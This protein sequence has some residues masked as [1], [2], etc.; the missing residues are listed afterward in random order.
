MIS[1]FWWVEFRGNPWLIGGFNMPFQVLLCISIFVCS[2]IPIGSMY[3][4]YANIGGI[5]MVNVTIYSIHGSYGIE[6]GSWSQKKLSHAFH[7]FRW[8]NRQRGS[9]ADTPSPYQGGPRRWNL[10]WFTPR[11]TVSSIFDIFEKKK[12]SKPSP[13]LPWMDINGWYQPST[14]AWFIGLLPVHHCCLSYLYQLS[15]LCLKIG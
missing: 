3:G 10:C 1:L 8:L 13:I 2:S 5:L 11:T 12:P 4:I 6:M 7:F 14:Y 9:T 15:W